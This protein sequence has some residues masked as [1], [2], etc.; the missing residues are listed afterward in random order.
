MANGDIKFVFNTP[1]GKGARTDEGRLRASAVAYGV[2]AVTTLPGCIAVAQALEAYVKDPTAK[3][4]ALQDWLK[5]PD[6]CNT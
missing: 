4:T 1:N 5:V 2:P 3:V 6:S